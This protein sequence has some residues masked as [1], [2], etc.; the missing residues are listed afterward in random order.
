MTLV[1]ADGVIDTKLTKAEAE[2]LASAELVI[3]QGMSSFLD[4]GDALAQIRED[5]L[6]RATHRTFEAYCIDRFGVSSSRARQL[7]L[8]AGRAGDL[9]S[10]TAVTLGSERAARAIGRVP[11][12]DRAEVLER[13]AINGVAEG[14][15]IEQAHA[16]LIAERMPAPAEPEHPTSEAPK[17]DGDPD[18]EGEPAAPPVDP[19]GQSSEQDDIDAAQRLVDANADLNAAAN[20]TWANSKASEIAKLAASVKDIDASE[21]VAW[22]AP[23]TRARRAGTADALADWLTTYSSALTRSG[24]TVHQG[25]AR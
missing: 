19:P 8:A 25:G 14:P 13:A 15:G 22:M 1:D 17:L 2:V 23:E 5:R 6:Y 11:A 16:D 10:V 18:R 7:I 12:E 9:E 4:V 24:L 20:R 21:L 3:K